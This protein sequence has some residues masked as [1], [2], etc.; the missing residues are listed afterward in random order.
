MSETTA[1]DSAQATLRDLHPGSGSARIA[2]AAL[3]H[4]VRNRIGDDLGGGFYPAPHRYQLYLSSG[5]PQSLRVSITLGLLRLGDSLTVT[6]DA[7]AALRAA[8]EATGHHYSGPLTVPALCDRWSGRIVSNHTPDI[9]SDLATRFDG[10][11]GVLLRPSALAADIDAFH[12]LFDEDITQAA[13]RAGAAPRSQRRG[14]AAQT[15][16]T[17]L[18]LLDHQL[19]SGP[20]LLGDALTAADVDLWVTLVHL[21]AVHRLHLDADTV[22]RIAAYDRLW[23]CVRRLHAS[24]AF[25]RALH[26]DHIARVHRRDCRGPESSGAAV[27]LPGVLRSSAA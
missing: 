24:P 16:L 26:P 8:Y 7:P 4:R 23:A 18:E 14:E 6:H 25:H 19:A 2:G 10:E 12:E 13:Q 5:C 1:H 11:H 3:A 21:D 27:T 20:Y 9:L 17:A 22:H 15:L